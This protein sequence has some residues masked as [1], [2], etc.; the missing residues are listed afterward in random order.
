MNQEKYEY[1]DDINYYVTEGNG[2]NAKKLQMNKK[3]ILS[4]LEANKAMV[5]LYFNKNSYD[6]LDSAYI[7]ELG[8]PCLLLT[9]I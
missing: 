3:S 4:L 6:K 9:N 5:L 1:I 7:R 2:D 8:R